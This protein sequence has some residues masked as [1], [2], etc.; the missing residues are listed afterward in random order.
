[1][2][3][4]QRKYYRREQENAEFTQ[5]YFVHRT[6]GALLA[7]FAYRVLRGII[8]LCVNSA[9]LVLRGELFLA[10]SRFNPLHIRFI[11][12][13]SL[14]LYPD[15]RTPTHDSLLRPYP[16]PFDDVIILNKIKLYGTQKIATQNHAFRNL[17]LIHI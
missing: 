14:P 6:L 9:P 13:N 2:L 3:R 5:R 16:Y 1:M 4:N 12:H 10:P 15:S 7:V 17:S 11:Q 8:F